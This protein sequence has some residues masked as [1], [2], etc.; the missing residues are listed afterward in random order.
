MD[1]HPERYKASAPFLANDTFYLCVTPAS[2]SYHII[3]TDAD[4]GKSLVR[5]IK[6]PPVESDATS[7][8]FFH[9]VPVCDP[10]LRVAQFPV[11]WIKALA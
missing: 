5:S 2:V 9:V 8:V 6:S 7:R 4:T 1:N 3:G 11:S 10:S